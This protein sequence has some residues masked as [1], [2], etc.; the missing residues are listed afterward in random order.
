MT[1]L[2]ILFML[3]TVQLGLPD[4]LL[5]SVCYVE[6]H[7]NVAAIHKADGHGDSIG[8]CQ[9]KLKTARQLGF[10]GSAYDLQ[11]PKVNIYYAGLYLKHQIARYRG[12]VKRAV[13][14]YNFGSAK[15][16]TSSKY[17]VKVFKVWRGKQYEF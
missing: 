16:F 8:I 7:H 3:N 13:I 5:S 17:Q 4:S 1:G 14:A 10:K 12:S 2:E 9:I 15:S 11:D 6:T